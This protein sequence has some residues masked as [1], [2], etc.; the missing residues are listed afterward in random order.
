MASGVKVA[1]EA[2]DAYDQIKLKKLNRYIIL[3]IDEAAGMI[4]V[5]KVKEK[6]ANIEQAAEYEDFRSQLP[7]DSGRYCIVDLTIPQKN[8]AMKDKLFIITW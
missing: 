5:E 4:K 7:L 8:G 3:Y 6:D 2:I 1:Q